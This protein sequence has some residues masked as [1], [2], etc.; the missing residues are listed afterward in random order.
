MA[1]I[2]ALYI[3]RSDIENE[4]LMHFFTVP[5]KENHELMLQDVLKRA[6]KYMSDIF[7]V[8]IEDRFAGKIAQALYSM[9]VD[10]YIERF[11]IAVNQRYKLK[12]PFDK[13]LLSVVYADSALHKTDKDKLILK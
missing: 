4:V 2:V 12:L 8:I 13:P 5:W 6:S 11:A 7:K 9:L 10:A 1:E 3:V